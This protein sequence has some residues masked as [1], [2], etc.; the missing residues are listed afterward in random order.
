MYKQIIE[1]FPHIRAFF[2]DYL[3]DEK[4]IPP[5]KFFWDVFSTLEQEVV[6]AIVSNTQKAWMESEKTAEGE[7]ISIWADLFEDLST[8]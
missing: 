6:K 4:Y 5:R 3:P 7:M 8:A 2:P 1:K